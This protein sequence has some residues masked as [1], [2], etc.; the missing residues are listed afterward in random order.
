MPLYKLVCSDVMPLSFDG[1]SRICLWP[2]LSVEY[3]CP[4]SFRDLVA[5][6]QTVAT[7]SIKSYFPH[8]SRLGLICHQTTCPIHRE[9]LSSDS[10]I[11]V[12]G[13][14]RSLSSG[15]APQGQPKEKCQTIF[16]RFPSS[17]HSVTYSVP[18][19]ACC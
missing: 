2:E 17:H 7:V 16:H 9:S 13:H 14:D 15:S 5:V 6:L 18:L 11:P 10:S 4:E 12:S 19:S 3:V 1:N 8:R